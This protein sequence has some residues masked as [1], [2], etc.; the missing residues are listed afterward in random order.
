MSASNRKNV[1]VVILNWNGKDVIE[2]C[3]DSLL[4]ISDPEFKI[5]VVDNAS[6]DGSD[7][8]VER[9][10]PGVELIRNSRNLLFAEGN[11]VGIRRALEQGADFI[12]L[13]NND[14]EV[15]P[16]FLK[17]MLSAINSGDRVGVVGPKIL[18]F[19]DKK[20]IW[21]GGGSFYPIIWVPK[22]DNIRRLDGSFEDMRS[23]TGYVTGCAML[24]RKE[25][26]EDVGLLDPSYTIYCE[27]VDFCLR[28]RRA[29][30]SCVY[31]PSARVY[32][33]V[34]FSSGGG[35]TPFK[36]ENRIHSTF[37]LHRRFKPLWWRIALFPVHFIAFSV[38]ILLFLFSGRWKLISPAFKGAIRV[39]R[40]R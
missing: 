16:D 2:A 20:R 5:I 23:E 39:L 22:H 8:V 18:Y 10:Y 29:G 4:R 3:I 6:S 14:T 26:I 1:F 40:S 9:K 11:N 38:M 13:L 15:A 12:L 25:V 17:N 33:K 34:S 27:D 32:H 28:A 35:L 19:D 37:L 21:Y 30:W 7:E 31:E 24:I 36:L